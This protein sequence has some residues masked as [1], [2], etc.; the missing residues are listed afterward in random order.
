MTPQSTTAK[1]VLVTAFEPFG[2]S[3]V[4]P[5]KEAAL[6]LSGW[7]IPERCPPDLKILVDLLPVVGGAG[8]GSGVGELIA[9]LRELRP[10]VLVALGESG[11]ATAITLER[12]AVN[13][14]D[15]RIPDNQGT[16]VSDQPV[17][18]G[19]PDAYFATLPLRAMQA[20]IQGLGIPAELSMSAGTF[21]CNELMYAALNYAATEQPG[22]IAGFI[23]V[24]QLPEQ[25]VEAGRGRASMD[26]LTIARGVAA[27]LS[28]LS[29]PSAKSAR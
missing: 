17:V 6:L 23:H 9:R 28:A 19:G 18:V 14:R 8:Q 16:V 26:R 10:D 25:V 11:Q 21:L 5:S 13:L 27:A 1:T 24:P 4:N 3:R 12:V 29:A 20:A 2:G 22:L 7:Q 15:Y